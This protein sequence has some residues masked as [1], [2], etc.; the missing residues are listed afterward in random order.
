[1]TDNMND[2]DHP[3]WINFYLPKDK[4]TDRYLKALDA[5]GDKLP[6][7]FYIIDEIPE[8]FGLPILDIKKQFIKPIKNKPSLKN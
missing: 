8:S 5:Y 2:Y 6:A 4:L 3:F 1:M 7:N